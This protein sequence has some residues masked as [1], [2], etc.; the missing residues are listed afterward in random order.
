MRKRFLILIVFIFI[1]NIIYGEEYFLQGIIFKGIRYTP[2]SQIQELLNIKPFQSYSQEIIKEEIQRIKNMGIFEDINY[3]LN[4]INGGYELIIKV[5]EYPI[6]KKVEFPKIRLLEEKE[7]RK[8]IYSDSGRFFILDKVQEDI[9]KIK[10]LYKKYGFPL[11][12]DPTYKFENNILSFIWEEIPPIKEVIYETNSNKEQELIKK[13]VNIKRGEDLNIIKIELANQKLLREE[14]PLIIKYN[15][16]IEDNGT[17][18]YLSLMPL[19]KNSFS[20][21]FYSPLNFNTLYSFYN[22]NIGKISI[23]SFISKESSPFYNFSWEK[24]NFHII[25]NNNYIS[26]LFLKELGRDLKVKIGYRSPLNP[27]GNKALLFSFERNNLV[28]RE[29]FNIKGSLL[30]LSMDFIGGGSPENYTLLRLL[31]DNYWSYG[32]KVEE[33]ILEAKGELKYILGN[34]QEKSGINIKFSYGFPVSLKSYIFLN[35]GGD[36]EFNLSEIRNFS[37]I[38]FTLWGGL[39][40]I[41]TNYPWIFKSSFVFKSIEKL[42]WEL[43]TI[44]NF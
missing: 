32:E 24:E 12:I 34:S 14:I 26:L 42:E 5:K 15:Y 4:K 10:D 37:D 44:L 40:F 13:L 31:T 16:K 6:I 39:D 33:R 30:N 3:F 7:I 20:F 18:L 41:W 27:Q 28:K 25:L 35:I 17:I 23:N 29:Y 11:A 2:Y 38:I 19:F 21:S 9:N 43:C 36:S 1:F 22:L 8:N